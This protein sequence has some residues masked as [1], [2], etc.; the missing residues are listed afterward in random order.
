MNKLYILSVLAAAA[1]AAVSFSVNPSATA[2]TLTAAANS[3]KSGK[4][5]Y[6][7]TFSTAAISQGTTPGAGNHIL[8]P[9]YY[10]FL[11]D[12]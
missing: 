2:C 6:A 1:S 3:Y 10:K 4:P 12:F 8:A 5:S 11:Y 7:F 9:C